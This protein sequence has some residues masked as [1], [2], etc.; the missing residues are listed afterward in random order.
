MQSLLAELQQATPFPYGKRTVTRIKVS[1]PGDCYCYL[2]F[3]DNR[4]I[5]Y[6]IMRTLEDLQDFTHHF[7]PL[8]TKRF[9]IAKPLLDQHL[10][11]DLVEYIV[12]GYL[13]ASTPPKR[14]S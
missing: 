5:K 4:V 6:Y 1:F 8:V 13:N 2:M 7:Q 11:P 9:Q 12:K 10:L 14:N 3:C